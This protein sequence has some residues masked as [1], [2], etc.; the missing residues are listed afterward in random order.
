MEHQNNNEGNSL[1]TEE[2]NSVM[3]FDER[4]LVEV[5]SLK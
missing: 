1:K 5:A 2:V 3:F 4:D